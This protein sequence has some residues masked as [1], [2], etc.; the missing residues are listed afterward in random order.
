MSREDEYDFLFKGITLL[1]SMARAYDQAP[2][3][4]EYTDLCVV[5]LIGDSGVGIHLDLIVKP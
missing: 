4:N 1:I 3:S 2:L 5:V